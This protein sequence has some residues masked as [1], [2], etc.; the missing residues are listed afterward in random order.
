MHSVATL[1][2]TLDLFGKKKKKKAG[3]G[4]R[5]HPDTTVKTQLPMN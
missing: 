1:K 5:P 3:S 4:G 2:L